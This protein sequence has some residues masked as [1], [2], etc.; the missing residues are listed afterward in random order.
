MIIAK[1]LKPE[2][3]VSGTVRDTQIQHVNVT[4][5]GFC[6]ATN[7][8][9][10]VVVPVVVQEGDVPGVVDAE[11]FKLSRK[12]ADDLFEIKLQPAFAVT[13]SG[14]KFPREVQAEVNYPKFDGFLP[15]GDSSHAYEITLDP[16]ALFTLAKAM[17]SEH[18][19]TLKIKDCDT[20]VIVEPHGTKSSTSYGYIMPERNGGD[21]SI[22]NRWN[23]EMASEQGV[24]DLGYTK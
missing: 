12:G 18:S 6:Q 2:L 9:V 15:H 20:V 23:P 16:R 21:A 4:P 3:C 13:R 1:A 8:W 19:V 14:A 24:S 7:G 22:W 17:A 11:A 10:A 5:D